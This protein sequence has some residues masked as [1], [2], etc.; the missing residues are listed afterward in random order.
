MATKRPCFYSGRNGCC[1]L[2]LRRLKLTFAVG[3]AS[4]SSRRA[5]QHICHVRRMRASPHPGDPCLR[6]EEKEEGGR[7]GI[8]HFH[9]CKAAAFFLSFPLS[10]SALSSRF[11][12]PSIP[13]KGEKR[14]NKWRRRDPFL[15]PRVG[16]G[17]NSSRGENAKRCIGKRVMEQGHL[18][19]R[20]RRRRI[21]LLICTTVHLGGQEWVDDVACFLAALRQQRK[22]P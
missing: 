14:C 5:L 9:S 20:Q 16:E 10:K 6:K 4:P 22:N 15:A 13:F 12:P 21:T 7:G 8:L 2:L 19:R 11:L 18:W 3:R 1:R 17:I